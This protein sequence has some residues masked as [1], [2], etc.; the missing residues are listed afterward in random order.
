MHIIY[1]HAGKV[2]EAILMHQELDPDGLAYPRAK[3]DFLILPTSAVGQVVV[4]GFED[5]TACIRDVGILPGLIDAEGAVTV[6]VP[7]A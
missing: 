7:E 4:D 5:A 6:P 3:V 2:A 1:S